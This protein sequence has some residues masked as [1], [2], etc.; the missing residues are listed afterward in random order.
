MSKGR[1]YVKIRCHLYHNWLGADVKKKITWA[2]SRKMLARTLK[3][4]FDEVQL[5]TEARQRSALGWAV[6]VDTEKYLHKKK[7]L[8][9]SE[10]LTNTVLA[11]GLTTLSMSNKGGLK[12]RIISFL[13]GITRDWNCSPCNHHQQSGAV[14]KSITVQ[15]YCHHSF[16]KIEL[17]SS[18]IRAHFAPSGIYRCTKLDSGLKRTFNNDHLHSLSDLSLER[19]EK[20][21]L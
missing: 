9:T 18:S 6:P 20:T 11:K 3:Q 19:S 4:T 15:T 5:Q 8:M 10:E 14:H 12:T 2:V 13:W 7:A 21:V 16:R 17:P 1:F